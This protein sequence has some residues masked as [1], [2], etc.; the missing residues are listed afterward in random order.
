MHINL[1]EPATLIAESLPPDSYRLW[2]LTCEGAKQWSR[3]AAQL[4][5]LL[6]DIVALAVGYPRLDIDA[7]IKAAL[8]GLTAAIES[9]GDTE[10]RSI[11][12]AAVYLATRHD[13]WRDA[14][15]EFLERNQI[16]LAYALHRYPGVRLVMRIVETDAASPGRVK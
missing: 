7:T 13:V 11:D 3:R 12:A 15:S 16:N 8:A 5:D 10:I 6:V 4:D 2:L 14:A 9:L 1:P